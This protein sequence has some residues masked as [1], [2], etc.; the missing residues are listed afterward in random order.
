MDTFNHSENH[1]EEMSQE[2]FQLEPESRKLYFEAAISES[3][4]SFEVLEKDYWVVWTLDQLFSL[5][6]LKDHLT[7]KGGTSLSKI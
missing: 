5:P 3:G 7:F 1:G 2:L 4:M 6:D